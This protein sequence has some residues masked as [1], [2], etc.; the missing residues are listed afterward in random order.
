MNTKSFSKRNW[1]LINRKMN[2]ISFFV[3]LVIVLSNSVGKGSLYILRIL[4]VSK[5][6]AMPDIILDNV[7]T[8]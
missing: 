8:F 7:I 2:R 6:S 3:H 5:M 4:V 1:T